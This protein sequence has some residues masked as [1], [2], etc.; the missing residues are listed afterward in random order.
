MKIAD[1]NSTKR[2]LVL[3][4][5]GPVTRARLNFPEKLNALSTDLIRALKSFFSSDFHS[6][7]IR[8]VV[9]SG[10]GSSFCA[11]ADINYMKSMKDFSREENL[12]DSKKLSNLFEVILNAPVPVIGIAHGNVYGGGIGLLAACDIAIAAEDTKFC[13]SEVKLGLA[14]AVISPFV[15]A[16]IGYNYARRYF[17][18]S[19]VFDAYRAYEM[20]LVQ[21]V[22]PESG[23]E[24]M[25]QKILKSLLK[26]GPQAQSEIKKLM[27][28]N[29]ALSHS[30]DESVNRHFTERRAYL[31]RLI[32]DLR[33]SDEAQE[34]M[35]AFIEKRKP[36]WV[37]DAESK[38]EK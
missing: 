35:Q 31:S 15:L 28:R 14:P 5:E 37:L 33:V 9:L 26:G 16:R 11:G 20:Q 18:S 25:T 6:I 23:L 30:E 21:E 19:E 10:E 3:K 36:L 4:T 1:E 7:G 2:Y 22:V 12:E 38:S 24:E 29:F 32:S 13:F 34:G 17:L 8:A 27:N